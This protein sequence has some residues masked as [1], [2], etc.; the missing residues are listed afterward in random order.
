MSIKRHSGGVA[1]HIVE[2]PELG[3]A[4]ITVLRRDVLDLLR[5]T[6]YRANSFNADHLL[7]VARKR[8]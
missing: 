7:L 1:R 3:V 6:L 4:P 2:L 5:S 8:T